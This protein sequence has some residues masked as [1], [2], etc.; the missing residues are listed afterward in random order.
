MVTYENN[1]QEHFSAFAK[2]IQLI[3][4]ALPHEGGGIIA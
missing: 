4:K 1:K 2:R 3:D